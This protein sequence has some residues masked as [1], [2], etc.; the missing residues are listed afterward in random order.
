MTIYVLG[1]PE[2]LAACLKLTQ[3]VHNN[4]PKFSHWKSWICLY[5]DGW[6]ECWRDNG[7]VTRTKL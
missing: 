7:M 6:Y 3:E 5:E 2:Y 1:S 4:D